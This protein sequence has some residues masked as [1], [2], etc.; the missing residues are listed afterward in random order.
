MI[1]HIIAYSQKYTYDNAQGESNSGY[2]EERA[3][4]SAG[5]NLADAPRPAR[6]TEAWS[7]TSN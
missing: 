1:D 7:I 3:G 4:H 2:P 5:G 6:W